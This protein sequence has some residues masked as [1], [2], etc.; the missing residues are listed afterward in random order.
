M[1]AIKK[2]IL[3]INIMV[4]A[5]ENWNPGWI[6]STFSKS[7]AKPLFEKKVNKETSYPTKTFKIFKTK[8]KIS[9]SKLKTEI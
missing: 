9:N 1:L 2:Q 8:C 7:T 5:S 3:F 4:M 6:F